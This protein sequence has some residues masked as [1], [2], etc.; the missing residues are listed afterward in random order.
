[1]LSLVCLALPAL[2]DGYHTITSHDVEIRFEVIS[3]ASVKL[4]SITN[5]SKDALKVRLDRVEKAAVLKPGKTA[6][7]GGIE[8]KLIQTIVGYESYT[9]LNERI[10]GKYLLST[11]PSSSEPVADKSADATGVEGKKLD[12]EVTGPEVQVEKTPDIQVEE[13][14]EKPVVNQVKTGMEE[15]PVVNQVKP[16][17]E[18][19]PEYRGHMEQKTKPVRQLVPVTE[20]KSEAD[21]PAPSPDVQDSVDS[22]TLHPAPVPDMTEP[23]AEVLLTKEVYS[24]NIWESFMS[25]L[26]SG[27]SFFSNARLEDLAKAVRNYRTGLDTCTNAI[28]KFKFIRNRHIDIYLD[29]QKRDLSFDEGRIEEI[30]SSFMDKYQIMCG[31]DSLT[32]CRDS[33]SAFL[34]DRADIRRSLL[35]DLEDSME[36]GVDFPKLTYS[37]IILMTVTLI[38]T[39]FWRRYMMG[40]KYGRFRIKF[41]SLKQS[42]CSALRSLFTRSSALRMLWS[43]RSFLKRLRRGAL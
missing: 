33:L 2:A 27:D 9:I 38:V 16:E 10:L 5:N 21:K 26:D 11:R 37:F 7:Y 39:L 19:K 14:E 1:M 8:C 18:E 29:K 41:A 23:V 3:P 28:R 35:C 12:A 24:G 25:E 43:P 34:S 22:S 31:A 15:R 42:P 17:A 30:V 6:E 32:A 13:V 20:S 40:R 36:V 4:Y